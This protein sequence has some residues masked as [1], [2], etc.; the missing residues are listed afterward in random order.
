MPNLRN[1]DSKRKSDTVIVENAKARKITTGIERTGKVPIAS[2]LKTLME[3]HE[4]LKKENSDN[5][6]EIDNLKLQVALLVHSKSLKTDPK[7]SKETQT[8]EQEIIAMKCS[9]SQES[10]TDF[11][12]NFRCNVCEFYS[13]TEEDLRLHIENQH[14]SVNP[15]HT[16]HP[17]NICGQKFTMKWELMVHRK[18]KHSS[19]LKTCTFYL[20]GNCAFNTECWFR[21][22]K[23][24]EIQ[25]TTLPKTLKEFKCGICGVKFNRK[26]DFMKH[27]KEEHYDN[28]SDCIENKNGACR[29]NSECWYKH[30][31][32]I[33]KDENQSEVD[34]IKTPDLIERLF[35]MM[36]AFAERMVHIEN[37]MQY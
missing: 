28:I 17:C 15:E 12:E 24:N 21:H 8:P 30:K 33:T 23:T 16:R 25:S 31:V 19:A 22:P 35:K 11:N 27:R 4:L 7:E 10:Q 26:K 2:Q 36:E 29:F 34:G 13:K 18:E 20:E 1:R 37:K 3:A 14:R 5:L 9:E 6:K 32:V